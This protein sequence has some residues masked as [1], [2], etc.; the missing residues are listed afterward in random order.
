MEAFEIKG[1]IYVGN[2]RHMGEP[3]HFI[4][5][6][7]EERLV[8]M[9]FGGEEKGADEVSW[10]RTTVGRYDLRVGAVLHANELLRRRRATESRE[11]E[12]ERSE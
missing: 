7:V 9:A 5:R 4:K 3:C 6:N 12:R 1:A 8:G 10:L 2:A 11:K